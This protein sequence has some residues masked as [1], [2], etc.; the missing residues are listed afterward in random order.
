LAGGGS[1]RGGRYP[2]L[3]EWSG[4]RREKT[5]ATSSSENANKIKTRGPASNNSKTS[6]M[7]KI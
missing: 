3:Y 2:E 1:V 7:K 6:V 4:T 5:I